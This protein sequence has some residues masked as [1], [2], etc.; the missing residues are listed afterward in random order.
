MTVFAAVGL[1]LTAA[2]VFG[3]LMQVVTRRVREIGIRVALGAAPAQIVRLVVGRGALL[4]A[5]GIA[6]GL[7]GAAAL[8]RFIEGILFGVSPRDPASFT[9]AAC[10]VG[11]A[12][13]AAAWVPVR[14]AARVD[15]A[16]LLKTE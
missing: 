12:A 14:R 16:A 5:G 7:A 3:V 6:A 9:V 8:V 11:A 4:L 13:L 1:V 2:G 15:A 10:V